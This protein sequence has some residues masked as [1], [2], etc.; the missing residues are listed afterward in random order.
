MHTIH[1]I[2]KKTEWES[3]FND[4][5]SPSFHHAWEWGQ[6]LKKCD[7]MVD[8][9]GLYQSS[10]LCAITLVVLMHAKRGNFLF[11][12]HGPVIAMDTIANQSRCN[13][14][15]R[16]LH[17]Y[18]KEKAKEYACNHIRIAP[19]LNDNTKNRALFHNHGYRK[20]PI[21]IH[22]E[23]M[24]VLDITPNEETLLAN[25]RK[26]TRYLIR[27]A[28]KEQVT[29]DKMTNKESFDIFM[30]LYSQTAKREHFSPF[31]RAYIYNEYS[32]FIEDNNALW[33]IGNVDGVPMAAALV[34]FTQST[35][36]YHQ[37]ASIHSKIPVPYLLQWEAIREAKRRGCTLYNFYGVHK[38]GR[39][40][41][42]WSGLTLFKQGFGGY[43][44]QY[45]PTQD[46]AL[47][48]AYYGTYLYEQLLNFKRGV[49][50]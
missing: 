25:M 10:K 39:T 5:G 11:V 17:T 19:C 22:S 47:S 15:M 43:Q 50:L 28:I 45:V 37:G 9:I 2:D 13:A 6:F 29:I 16:T 1:T 14:I 18:L 33:L 49:Y 30:H 27:K 3:F 7:H 44:Q 4:N 34:I 21:Y 48:P 42:N 35:A 31:S 24:W 36:F 8:Y 40:P 46:Y 41:K 20:A 38:P 23:T 32:S 12:P 26:T